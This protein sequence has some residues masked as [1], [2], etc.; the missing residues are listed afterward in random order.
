MDLNNL[1]KTMEI[2]NGSNLHSA[3]ILILLYSLTNNRKNTVKGIMKLAKLDFLLRYPT[4][5]EKAISLTSN[6]K[7]VK[8]YDHERNA[9]ESSMIRYKYGPWDH[10]FREYLAILESKGLIISFTVKNV[11]NYKVTDL[12]IYLTNEL[13][14]FKIF[15]DYLDRSII[16]KE[17]FGS[18]NGTKLKE[19]MYD[20]LPKLSDMKY[21]DEIRP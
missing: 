19:M 9:V 3:R 2:T 15:R 14:Q 11:T 8:I 1:I 18:L 13:L 4:V 6:E 5:L 16:I 12:G 21:G 17:C 20:L 10:R 7:I